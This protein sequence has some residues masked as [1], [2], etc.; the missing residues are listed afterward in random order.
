MNQFN[1]H[2]EYDDYE[3]QN[4]RDLADERYS[5]CATEGEADREYA[6]N[7]GREYPERAWILSDRDVWYAN[8]FYHGPAVPHPEADLPEDFGGL[9]LHEGD[10]P[11]EDYS[12]DGGEFDPGADYE[13]TEADFGP[14]DDQPAKPRGFQPY[15]GKVWS[16]DDIP[17]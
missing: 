8:P 15:P 12:T 6:Y 16:D 13:P 2:S 11:R 14:V 1:N 3:A 9:P 4:L 10:G 7:V 5:R 17:F